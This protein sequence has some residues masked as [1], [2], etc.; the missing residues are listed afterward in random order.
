MLP[1]I[2]LPEEPLTMVINPASY[3]SSFTQIVLKDIQRQ[4]ACAVGIPKHEDASAHF[5][6]Y[7]PGAQLNK[8]KRH[9]I[10]TTHRLNPLLL[11]CN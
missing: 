1:D 4:I 2:K 11:L 9:S 6:Y 3:S 8:A 5:D 7:F 10:T